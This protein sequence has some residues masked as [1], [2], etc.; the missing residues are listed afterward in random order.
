M[1]QYKKLRMFLHA[2]AT[3]N[4]GLQDDNLTAFIRFGNDFTDNFYQVEIPLKVTAYG[5]SSPDAIW[6]LDNEIELPLSLLTALKSK[7]IINALGAP[8][9]NGIHFLNEQ[10]LGS[11]KNRLTLGIK[12]NPN[13]GLVRTLMIG[14][15]N[16]TGQIQRGEVWFNEL[17]MS[18]MDN[19]GGYAAVANLDSN[20]A[21]FANVSATT[22]MSTIGFGSLEQGPNERSREDV[23]QY[24]IVT[25]INLGKLLPKR[26][27]INLPFNYG[28]GEQTI[29]PKYDPFYQDIELQQLLDLTTNPTD[30][31]NIENRA[32]D[33]TKRTSI[34][35]IGVKKEK[36]PEKKPHFYDVENLTLSYSLN[37][38]QH[39]DYEIENLIDQQNRST[40]DYAFSFKP[41]TVEPFKETKVF[42]KSNYYKLL[43]DFNF[44]FL[45]T[46]ISF[47]SNSLV[48]I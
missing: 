10:D 48:G 6:P 7:K 12:G 19:K 43:S 32:I 38:T 37:E 4:G 47:S 30:R 1:R 39:H 28:V 13:F 15:K 26:W 8:D 14:I 35:L 33:Y 42:K 18:D 44:N 31:S 34:N 20:L 21:D 24:D 41:L 45:P 3:E 27:G 36:N 17:R 11:S 40:V 2:E 16:K 29:T 23:F 22:R 9:V 25:N 5:E 46:N